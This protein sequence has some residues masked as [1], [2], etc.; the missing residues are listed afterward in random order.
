VSV[1]LNWRELHF[2]EAGL[3]VGNPIDTTQEM[4]VTLVTNTCPSLVDANF[5]AFVEQR[6]G[7]QRPFNTRSRTSV[8]YPSAVLRQSASG[9]SD[10]LLIQSFVQLFEVLPRSRRLFVSN[11][12]NEGRPRVECC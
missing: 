11:F 7:M 10:T 6:L 9:V 2:G 1:R 8:S 3:F 12:V 5:L 4:S